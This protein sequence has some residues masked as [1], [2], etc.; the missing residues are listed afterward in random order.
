MFEGQAFWRV[1]RV[2]LYGSGSYLANPKDQN[3]TP[4]IIAILGLSTT[5]GQFAGLG[6][7][8]VPDQ[9]VGRLGGSVHVWKG[10]SAASTAL[11]IGSRR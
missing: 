4:S 7:N 9:Y 8:S 5:T 1:K 11:P 2:F 3:E 10:F 6:L